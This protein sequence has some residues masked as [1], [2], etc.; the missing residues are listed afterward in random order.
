M[1]K[2]RQCAWRFPAAFPVNEGFSPSLPFDL[3]GAFAGLFCDAVLE[4]QSSFLRG[5]PVFA[6]TVVWQSIKEAGSS[7]SHQLKAS[8]AAV[9]SFFGNPGIL[10]RVGGPPTWQP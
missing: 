6:I 4:I 9:N 10:S 8:T 2:G 1:A 5:A 3:G 7:A